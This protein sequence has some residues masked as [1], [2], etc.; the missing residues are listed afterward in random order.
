MFFL[1]Q[2]KRNLLVIV[3]ILLTISAL[4]FMKLSML[5][6][7]SPDENLT[8]ILDALF[9]QAS[10]IFLTIFIIGLIVFGVGIGL[11]FWKFKKLFEKKKE[12]RKEEKKEE[13]KEENKPE[14]KS[15]KKKK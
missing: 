6:S 8:K 9:A 10:K 1:V 4:P 14:K 13:V 5:T 15:D 11:R 2:D 3:G 12:E 7:L